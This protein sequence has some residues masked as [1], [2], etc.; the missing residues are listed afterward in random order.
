MY[1]VSPLSIFMVLYGACAF[2]CVRVDVRACDMRLCVCV[3]M[4]VQARSG[5]RSHGKHGGK[6]GTHL[7]ATH[8]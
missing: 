6:A 2:A 8:V 1:V 3:R 5:C 7:V 4:R